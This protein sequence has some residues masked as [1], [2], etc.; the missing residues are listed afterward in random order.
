ME[1][2]V[3]SV[4]PSPRDWAKEYAELS[5]SDEELAPEDLERGAVAAHVL[6]EDEQAVSLLDRAHRSYLEEGLPDRAARCVFWLIFHLRNAGQ[7][8]RAAGWIARLRRILEDED[9]DD[10]LSYLALLGEGV[11]L[12]QAGAVND[13]LPMVEQAAAGARA[14]GDD[15]LFVL[16]GLARGRCL[17]V[18]GQK[19][20]SLGALDEIMVYA[21]ADRVAPQ[22]VG[23]AYC[24]VISLCMDRFDLQRAAEWTQALTRWC[25]AQ[26]GLMP[27]RG[28]CQVHRAEILQLHGSWAEAAA[29]AAQVSERLPAAGFVA[30]AAH[31]R[32][33]ELHRLRGQFDLAERSY[34]AAASCGREVQ[35]G[36]ALI[37]LA[38]GNP[39]AGLA[40]LDRALAE[41]RS[42]A[43]RSLLLAAKVEIALA[44]GTIDAARTALGELENNAET[45]ETP[46]MTALVAHAAGRVRL[47][48]DD[49][50]AALPLLRR[51]W[52]L[53]QQVDAP[54][55]AARTR[56][57][58]SAACRAL[59]DED[60]ARMELDAARTVFEQ[61]GAQFDLA[62]LAPVEGAAPGHPLTA[63][64]CEVLALVAQGSTNRGIAA[65]LFLSEKTVARHLSN[66]F[67]KINVNSR[68]A[69]TAYAYEHG[70]V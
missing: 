65:K 27:Y 12:M 22:V 29:E 68:A 64:E 3:T 18:Q 35:P 36:L 10:H 60:A 11:S 66:I 21:V 33:A 62:S 70:L 50:Q 19:R 40:G 38:Q 57:Q 23:L 55:E 63:R 69:A 59:G 34:A 13:A 9:P 44:A 24:S 49:P 56:V 43:R 17:D 53:W 61:L 31:Y 28:E 7:T 37:R 41:R 2:N 6:G 48:E 16:A 1:A 58:V 26:S 52:T 39:A 54:Y 4:R 30:G 8:A 45:I 67:T 46:Y 42:P 32:L 14:A 47:A 20:Q 25:D 51:A 5:A 15:D